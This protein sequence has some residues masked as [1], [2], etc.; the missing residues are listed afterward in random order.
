MIDVLNTLIEQKLA[1]FT[2][3]KNREEYN[4]QYV[5]DTL[6]EAKRLPA[7]YFEVIEPI[8]WKQYG[9]NFQSGTGKI[10]L[11]VVT[12]TM[13]T[14]TATCRQLCDQLFVFIQGTAFID[15]NGNQLTSELMRS[16]TS[17]PKRFRILKVGIIEFDCELYDYAAIPAPGVNPGQLEVNVMPAG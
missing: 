7:I 17:F 5:N 15:E 1:Q 16:G 2:Q 8:I 4:E 9:Q 12:R 11:H 13:K 3:V 6:E 14:D 10:R